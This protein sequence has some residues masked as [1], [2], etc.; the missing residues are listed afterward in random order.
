VPGIDEEVYRKKL[1]HS[2]HGHDINNLI[3]LT[4]HPNED[5]GQLAELPLPDMLESGGEEYVEEP[6][7]TNMSVP[8]K[9]KA[10]HGEVRRLWPRTWF[11]GCD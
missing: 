8:R 11:E 1:P 7:S 5:N 4:P 9:A 10:G 3:D 6:C 2:V